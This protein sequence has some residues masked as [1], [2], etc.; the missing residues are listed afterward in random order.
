MVR[1]CWVEILQKSGYH[2]VCFTWVLCRGYEGLESRQ[3]WAGLNF[4]SGWSWEDFLKLSKPPFE[5]ET[6]NGT[7]FSQFPIAIATRLRLGECIKERGLFISL[8][9]RLE[10]QDWA[11][12]LIQPLVKTRMIGSP[13]GR[14]HHGGSVC[15][16]RRDHMVRESSRE[17]VGPVSL[18]YNNPLSWELKRVPREPH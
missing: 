12:S 9:W 5:N 15:A 18:F 10:V 1:P 4:I 16:R 3:V 7:C 11:E 2:F 17:G 6:N 8:F 13:C 14:W